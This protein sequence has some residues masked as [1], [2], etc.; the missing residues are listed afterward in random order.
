VSEAQAV[1]RD[2]RAA[3]AAVPGFAAALVHKRL[4][5]GPTN[6]SWLIELGGSC[7]V[8]RLDLPEAQ[9]LGLDRA[10]EAAVRELA[11]AA[12]LTP[13]AVHSD[14]AAGIFVRRFEPGRSWQP[15]D[16]RNPRKLK[17]LAAI[18]R[19][20]H[21]LPA[22]GPGFAPFAAMQRYAEQ[23]GSAK[24]REFVARARPIRDA[25]SEDPFRPSLCH[26]DLVCENIVEG[27]RLQL[28]DW[29]YAGQGDPLF[30]L[31]VVIQHH[32]MEPDYFECLLRA[33]FDGDV[34]GAA[35]R[36]LRLQCEFYQTLLELWNLRIGA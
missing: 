27:E 12:G 17:R 10:G 6:Q 2:V 30:D 33:Y 20:L 19:S 5:A 26:N 11:A 13:E 34:P 36:R 4:S 35:R 24:A 3:L 31:A 29:E 14:R 32:G 7:Y 15:A 28:I 23:L 1:P 22:D 25:L 18:L 8:L 9:R 16:L 21:R